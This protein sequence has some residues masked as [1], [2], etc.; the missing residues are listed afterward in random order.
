M[1]SDGGGGGGWHLG[2]CLTHSASLVFVVEAF[3]AAAFPFFLPKGYACATSF[4]NEGKQIEQHKWWTPPR[5][6]RHT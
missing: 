3:L 1:E 6:E 4:Q 2:A 5:T